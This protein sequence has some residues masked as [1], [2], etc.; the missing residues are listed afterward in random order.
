MMSSFHKDTASADLFLIF[1]AQTNAW[2][3]INSMS[4]GKIRAR[5]I[6]FFFQPMHRTSSAFDFCACSCREQLCKQGKQRK[7]LKDPKA[8]RFFSF[9]GYVPILEKM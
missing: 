1:N 2:R 4:V 7:K 8:K 3:H 6:I 5:N 9:T